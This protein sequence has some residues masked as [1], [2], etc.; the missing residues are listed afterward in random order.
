MYNHMLEPQMEKF[1]KIPSIMHNM[2]NN[3]KDA[4]IIN[5]VHDLELNIP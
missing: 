2:H 5:I 1:K 4:R 3:V